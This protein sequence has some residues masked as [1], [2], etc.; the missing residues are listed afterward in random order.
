MK[1]NYDKERGK[2]ETTDDELSNVKKCIKRVK[3]NVRELEKT[4][5]DTKLSLEKLFLIA[6]V[7]LYVSYIKIARYMVVKAYSLH[8]C[9]KSLL[10]A[11]LICMCV[12]VLVHENVHV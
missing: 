5:N 3:E 10:F 7:C 1:Q 12:S 2:R 4:W 11:K 8:A 6:E 9:L